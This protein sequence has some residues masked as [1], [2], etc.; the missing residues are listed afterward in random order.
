MNL[1]ELKPNQTAQILS[2]DIEDKIYKLRLC[3]LGLF[4]GAEISLI[5]FSL[6]K[7]T[8]LLKI[9]NSVFEIK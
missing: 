4:Q 8:V 1:L 3:E 2:I 7:R 9:F 6:L 5:Y